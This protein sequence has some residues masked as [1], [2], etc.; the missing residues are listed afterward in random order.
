MKSILKLEELA[1][2]AISVYALTLFDA[3]WWC[4]LLMAL[5]P[6]ISMIGYAAGNQVGAIAYNIFH[7]KGVAIALFLAGAFLAMPVLEI[8]GII[9]FGHASMDRIFGY[10]LKYKDGFS[11]THLGMIGKKPRE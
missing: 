5:G 10:G 1:M 11:H 9:L 3:P 8:A 7:H 4:Y 6:D 2:L